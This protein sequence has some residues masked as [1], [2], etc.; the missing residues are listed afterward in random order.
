MRRFLGYARNDKA[1]REVLG[2]TA[3]AVEVLGSDQQ[4]RDECHQDVH[5]EEDS[6][7]RQ[8]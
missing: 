4:G 5:A 2:M 7:K 6:Q 3:G 8:H 1:G